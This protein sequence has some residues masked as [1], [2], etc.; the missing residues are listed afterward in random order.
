[1]EAC[2]KQVRS[3]ILNAAY[4]VFSQE[5]FH[6]GS[7]RKISKTSSLGIPTIYY[8]FK[9]KET[10]C[11]KTVTATH[12]SLLK[13]LSVRSIASEETTFE[14]CYNYFNTLFSICEIDENIF[15][16]LFVQTS[17]MPKSIQQ[18]YISEYLPQ[19]SETFIT[20]LINSNKV[21]TDDILMLNELLN[22]TLL[23][24]G[25]SATILKPSL[26]A[27]EKTLQAILN[28]SYVLN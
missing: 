14:Y 17:T 10:L 16:F 28:K 26:E 4:K 18:Q 3:K 13:L 23:K 21:N 6:Q 22:S 7:I 25:S 19:L 27:I 5:G 2:S 11:E 24:M 20:A 12:K 1:M 15:R 8:H 9:N